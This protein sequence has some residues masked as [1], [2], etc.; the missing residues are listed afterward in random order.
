MVSLRFIN[1]YKLILQVGPH[2]VNVYTDME[3]PPMRKF[4]DTSGTSQVSKPPGHDDVD[5]IPAIYI[6]SDVWVYIPGQLYTHDCYRY[7]I[8]L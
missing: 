8:I 5:G 1:M 6:G 2:C 3:N 7:C 4:R